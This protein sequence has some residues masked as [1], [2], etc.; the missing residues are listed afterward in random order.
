MID[1]RMTDPIEYLAKYLRDHSEENIPLDEMARLTGY[2]PFHLQRRFKAALGVSPKQFHA[3]ARRERLKEKL[4][5][6][7]NVT[8][9]LY[10]T[11]YGSASRVYENVG[12]TLGMT[13]REYR[14]RG[15]GVGISYAF[16]ASPL[17]WLLIAATDRGLCFLELGDDQAVLRSRLEAEFPL[18]EPSRQNEAN[19]AQWRE[20]IAAYLAGRA[21]PAHLPLDVRSTAFQAEV[22]RFLTTIPLGETRSYSEVAAALGKPSATRAVARACA[23]NPVALAIPCH[24]VIR[25]NG[26]LGGYRWGL[27]R[28][29]QLLGLE[30][31]AAGY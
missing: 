11:G 30:Q 22:W 31:K 13:P 20:A 28:K 29:A 9:A 15:R 16:F 14:D 25:Q 26:D 7:A 6:E 8:G 1:T 10:E 18:A 23:A 5:N 21:L 27:E 17:G 4:R 3:Q 12:S 2:S 24:R 19:L